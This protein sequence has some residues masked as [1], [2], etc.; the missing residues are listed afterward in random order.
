MD[1]IDLL[2]SSSSD[3]SDS[4]SEVLFNIFFGTPGDPTVNKI[5]VET[6]VEDVIDKY[7]DE[8]VIISTIIADCTIPQISR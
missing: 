6:F 7:S 4:D 5:R 1:L 8:Q 2:V 3:D